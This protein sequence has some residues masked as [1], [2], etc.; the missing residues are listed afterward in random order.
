MLSASCFFAFQTFLV[1]PD[2]ISVFKFW[3]LGSI[4]TEIYVYLSE[5]SL[6]LCS[7]PENL[8]LRQNEPYSMEKL[9]MSCHTILLLLAFY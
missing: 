2:A 3:H 8:E 9:C 6:E 5:I 1:L 4:D 7:I